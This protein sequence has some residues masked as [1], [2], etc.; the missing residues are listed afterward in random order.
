MTSAVSSPLTLP[1]AAVVEL[2]LRVARLVGG[3]RDGRAGRADSWVTLDNTGGA[4]SLF[5]SRDRCARALIAGAVTCGRAQ[6]VT[7]V[8]GNSGI[9]RH[10]VRAAGFSWPSGA[11][12]SRNCTPT[13]PTLSVA[14]AVTGIEPEATAPPPGEVTETTGAVPSSV[15]NVTSLETPGLPAVSFERTRTWYSV[16]PASPLTLTV[17][18]VTS[19]ESAGSVP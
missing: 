10:R 8:G 3:P 7:A 2:D 5:T 17:C 12:S 13:T 15:A 18:D 1:C 14:V 6:R 19:V 11:P 9:P 4:V 16:V